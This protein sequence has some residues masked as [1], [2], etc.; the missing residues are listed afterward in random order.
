VEPVTG[1]DI[2]DWDADLQAL[3]QGL[4]WM[5][6]RPE[7][8]ATFGLMVW[9]LL[10][11]VP[12]ENL[13]GLAEHVGLATPRPF[14]HLLDGAVWDAD[15]LRDRVRN[16]VVAG[17]GSTDAA[18]IAEDTTSM[19]NDTTRL[20]GLDGLCHHQGRPRQRDGRW[21]TWRPLMSGHGPVPARGARGAGQSRPSRQE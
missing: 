7:P 12:K 14:E 21:C 4:G 1:Q 5:V 3:T 18:L 6:N 11:D 9:A 2:A 16:Y 10:A 8:K 20:L 13:S 15:V 17:L 19:V